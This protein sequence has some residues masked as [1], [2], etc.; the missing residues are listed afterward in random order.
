MKT[1]FQS[2]YDR[3]EQE[4]QQLEKQ[5]DILIQ[6]NETYSP[7]IEF[8]DELIQ[9][10][11]KAGLQFDHRN[12]NDTIVQQSRLYDKQ[13]SLYDYVKLS[14]S[15]G[16]MVGRHKPL[17][18]D[19]TYSKQ[20]DRRRDEKC[21]KL[22]YSIKSLIQLEGFEIH[23][24][25]NPF[26]I[27]KEKD[28]SFYGVLLDLFFI[29]TNRKVLYHS[30]EQK[31]NQFIIHIFSDRERLD[32]VLT[33]NPMYENGLFDTYSIGQERDDYKRCRLIEKQL[34]KKQHAL[35]YNISEYLII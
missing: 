8:Y 30:I 1:L 14:L 25:I 3:K 2:I 31:N 13:Y 22:E 24:S 35:D 4:K 28:D 17:K 5:Q 27:V 32:E 6:L 11:R 23:V 15:K 9:L 18:Y 20:H 19:W 34:L 10:L 21:A 16:Q 12:I 26:S 29:S 7:V 33:L